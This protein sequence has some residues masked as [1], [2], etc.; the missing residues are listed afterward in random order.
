MRIS[1]SSVS[2]TRPANVTAYT[3]GDIVSNDVD[4]ADLVPLTFAN[5]CRRRGGGVIRKVRLSTS[6]QDC[7]A[8]LRLHLY[9]AAPTGLAGDNA[10]FQHKSENAVSYLGS[11]DLAALST[12]VGVSTTAETTKQ[13]LNFPFT[14]A[15]LETSLY[16]IL[17]DRTGFTPA[18]GQTFWVELTV[19]SE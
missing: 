4:A 14:T 18:S 9:R 7:V 15:D 8:A 2:Q 1:S 13:D 12:A 11:I 19:E 10:A 17:E 6:K 5:V 16:G 3:I